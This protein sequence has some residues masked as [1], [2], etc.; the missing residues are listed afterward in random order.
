MEPG[1][2]GAYGNADATKALPFLGKFRRKFVLCPNPQKMDDPLA[3]ALLLV[4]WNWSSQQHLDNFVKLYFERGFGLVLALRPTA[5]HTYVGDPHKH[6]SP[7]LLGFIEMAKVQQRRRQ[8]VLHFFSGSCY[9]YIRLLKC[10]REDFEEDIG[11]ERYGQVVRGARYAHL[12]GCVDA[13]I[14]DST[15][16]ENDAANGANALSSLSNIPEPVGT[17]LWSVEW[18]LLAAYWY[19]M[20]GNFYSAHDRDFYHRMWADYF[21]YPA[22]RAPVLFIYAEDDVVAP[23]AF[24]EEQLARLRLDGIDATGVR[25]PATPSDVAAAMPTRA[26]AAHVSHFVRHPN[27]Y[28]KA[29]DS[30]LAKVPQDC[31]EPPLSP[32][33]VGADR[34]LADWGDAGALAAEWPL[35]EPHT[36]HG[37]RQG[38][39]GALRDVSGASS[40]WRRGTSRAA[41][42][43]DAHERARE[44]LAEATTAPPPPLLILPRDS[45]SLSSPALWAAL[46]ESRSNGIVTPPASS[47][48]AASTLHPL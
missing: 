3:P 12:A 48:T 46:R 31:S 40:G 5:Y 25:F 17:L 27:F 10:L 26:K 9:L 16:I 43:N 13:V 21:R 24:V 35:A 47:P 14:F 45:V 44:A 20:W 1:Q 34:A 42:T 11:Q 19:L 8:L 39:V 37:E 41:A 36:A 29:V 6:I 7:A 15:P 32:P 30:I 23:Y 38:R 2:L 33:G 4:G 28:N 22:I 18:C